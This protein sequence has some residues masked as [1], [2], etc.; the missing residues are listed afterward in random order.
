MITRF[1][2]GNIILFPMVGQKQLQY[3]R[4]ANASVAPFQ[5]NNE[6]PLVRTVS[7]VTG[8]RVKPFAEAVRARDRRC[9]I[10]GE[11]AIGAQF[12]NWNGFEA[13]HIFP[14]AYEGYWKENDYDRWIT[15]RPEKGGTI[16]SVQ[17]GL[18]LRSDIH[19]LFDSYDFSVNPDVSISISF[20]NY[21]S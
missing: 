7:H 12:D 18:L 14:L 19:Q 3:G 9:V 1:N 8:T 5:I 16:N 21:Y 11:V 6:K 13:A 15:I 4:I 20:N 2:P 10:S 17:N